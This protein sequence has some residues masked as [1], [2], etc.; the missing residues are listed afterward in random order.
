MLRLLRS[1]MAAVQASDNADLRSRIGAE[2]FIAPYILCD[3]LDAYAIPV[4]SDSV[5]VD[6]P[7]C[8]ADNRPH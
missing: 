3:A 1:S 6:G 4:P 7:M 8:S 5:T 2:R